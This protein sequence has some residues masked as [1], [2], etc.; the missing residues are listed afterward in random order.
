MPDELA[1]NVTPIRSWSLYHAIRGNLPLPWSSLCLAC[2]LSFSAE[3]LARTVRRPPSM[4]RRSGQR[5]C[6][7][8]DKAGRRQRHV[9]L[10]AISERSAERLARGLVR[11]RERERKA[12]DARPPSAW[13]VGG[14]QSGKGH[15]D[16]TSVALPAPAGLR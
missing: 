8:A 4:T 14:Q 1:K 11:H 12:L 15:A 16:V 5:P 3:A 9:H 2:P 6:R 13:T 7:S 10:P